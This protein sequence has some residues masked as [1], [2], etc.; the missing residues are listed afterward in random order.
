MKNFKYK[1]ET[2]NAIIYVVI[3]HPKQLVGLVLLMTFWAVIYW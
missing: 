1:N 2:I 3:P